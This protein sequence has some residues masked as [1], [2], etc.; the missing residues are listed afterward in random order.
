MKASQG[1]KDQRKHARR[2][3]E[4]TIKVSTVDGPKVAGSITFES[5]DLSE[6]GAFLRSDLLL[7]EGELLNVEI[8]L[9]ASRNVRATARVVR[10]SRD[11]PTGAGMGIEFVR[12]ADSDRKLLLLSLMALSTSPA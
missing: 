8:P 10:T 3:V 2:G 6:G 5:S 12:L 7:E 11:S 4:L 1:R 9:S